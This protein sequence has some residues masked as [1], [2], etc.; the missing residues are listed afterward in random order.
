METKFT[1]SAWYIFFLP[2]WA[3]IVF[4]LSLGLA[5]PWVQCAIINWVV[6]NTTIGGKR[7]KFNGSGG[8]LFG[9]YIIWWLLTIVTIG[10]YIPM[11]IKNQIR[12]VVEN[13]QIVNQ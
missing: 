12:Y 13:I 9:R 5:F 6:K 3:G 1:G 10:L 11:S 2:F 7:L 8:G 4:T